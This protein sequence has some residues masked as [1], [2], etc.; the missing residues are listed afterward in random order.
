[1][2]NLSK[3]LPI[4]LFL[5]FFFAGLAAFMQSKPS[6]KEARVYKIIKEYSPYYIEKTFGGLKILSK[7]NKDFK[8]EPSNKDFFKRYE[9]L[10][11]SWGKEHLRLKGDILEIVD[12]NKTLKKVKLQNQKEINFIHRYYGVK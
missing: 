1:M 3:Y 12:N 5:A 8:E 6:H 9:E 2:K 11:K 10:E 7:T 4:A